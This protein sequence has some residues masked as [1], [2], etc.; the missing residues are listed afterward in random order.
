MDISFSEKCNLDCDYCFV[1]KTSPYVLDFP[2]V[3][4][5]VDA[6]FDLEGKRKTI[7]FTT[8]EPF[9]YPELF[10]DSVTY[11]FR[12][13]EERG[14]DI[15][16]IATTNGSRFDAAM[17]EFVLSLDPKR[18][19][20]N[21]S[22]DGTEKS[23]DAH[24]KFR[25]GKRAGS[26]FDAAIANFSAYPRRDLVRVIMTIAP[27]EAGFL[28]ENVDFI[29]S[30]GF[31]NIDIF[32]QMFVI[33]S[34]ADRHTFEDGLKDVV[35]SFNS[36]KWSERNLRLLNRLWGDTHYAKILLGSDG[37]FYLFEWVLPL[38]YDDRH[39]YEIGDPE[40]LS[41]GKRNALF[42]FLFEK[43]ARKN[44][45]KCSSCGFRPFCADPIPLYLWATHR[46]KDFDPHFEN[47]CLMAGI[48]IRNSA[49]VERKNVLD[50]E[51]WG[52]AEGISV[53]S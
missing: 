34:D 3:R 41:V 31:G 45:G 47:F 35:E 12:S 16:I 28:K 8:S 38:A 21:F 24:R 39:P 40:N 37:K 36:G 26:T 29:M 52:K 53:V 25:G 44:G 10:R 43:T 13:A 30:Q 9:L 14:I 42:A 19:T 2:T 1:D 48:M 33:W 6:F 46:R 18:F 49:D 15:H 23:H 27:S 7:T 4:K 20:L 50:V 32:P 17:R 5:A 11:I 22:L 51:K